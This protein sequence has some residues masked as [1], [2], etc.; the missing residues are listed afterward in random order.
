MTDITM[1][2]AGKP[3]APPLVAILRKDKPMLKFIR[4]AV[5]ALILAPTA[6][7]A[8]DFAA[9]LDAAEQGDYATALQEFRPLAE[10]GVA[11]AQLLLGGMYNEG[12]GVPQ[13]YAEAAR[14]Y[15]LA[16]E[17]G[18]AMAQINLGSKYARGQGVPQDYAEAVKWWRLAAEQGYAS[19]QLALGH[20]Y[21][22]GKGVTQDYAEA[23][24]WYR[25]AAEQGNA[26]AQ[27]SLGFMYYTSQGVPKD[28][29]TAHMWYNIAAEGGTDGAAKVRDIVAKQ[30]TA[31]DI[32]EAQRR[33][34]MCVNSGYQ[35]CD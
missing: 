1:I 11:E 20:S 16:A 24:R 3:P 17:Q 6:G 15:R 26:D 9:G 2:R 34:Q 27:A 12:L 29:T 18:I 32:S 33:A 5:V 23:A 25:L 10:Q 13:D 35:E 19:A 7:A 28:Y 14:W 21:Y 4:C 31:A 30:M 8:Q 22:D